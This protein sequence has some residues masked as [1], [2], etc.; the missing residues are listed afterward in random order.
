MKGAAGLRALVAVKDVKAPTA[1]NWAGGSGTFVVVRA[2]LKIFPFSAFVI[3]VPLAFT[4]GINALSTLAPLSRPSR[5][6]Y[7]SPSKSR[8][9]AAIF[10]WKPPPVMSVSSVGV[11]DPG[12]NAQI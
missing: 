1:D 2:S 5:M 4:G 3:H 12:A 11:E 6:R 8:P 7:N 10:Q 9:H